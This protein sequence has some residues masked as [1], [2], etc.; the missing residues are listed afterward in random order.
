MISD[1]FGNLDFDWDEE[2]PPETL[3][4]AGSANLVI[5]DKYTPLFYTAEWTIVASVGDYQITTS[6][7]TQKPHSSTYIKMWTRQM[8]RNNK[9]RLRRLGVDVEKEY[10]NWGG[11]LDDL[12]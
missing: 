1:Q 12:D 6:S 4:L 8:I 5:L 2:P 9:M 3:P 10:V 11:I 7:T